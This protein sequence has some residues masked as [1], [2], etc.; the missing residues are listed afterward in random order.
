MDGGFLPSLSPS[1][2]QNVVQLIT[3][4]YAQPSGAALGDANGQLYDVQKSPLAW[5]LVVPLLT[6]GAPGGGDG[7]AVHFFGAHT[8]VVKAARD[9]DSLPAEHRNAFRDLMLALT[10][11]SVRRGRPMLVLRKL[12]VCLTSLAIRLAPRD[13]AGQAWADWVLVCFTTISGA[14]SS[15]STR[16]KLLVHEFLTIAAEE[17]PTADVV[18]PSRKAQLMQTLIDSSSIIT[19]MIRTELQEPSSDNRPLAAAVR[20]L[21]AWLSQLRADDLTSLI[22]LLLARLGDGKDA[23]TFT[24]IASAL[25]EILSRAPAYQNGAGSRTLTE[26][27]LLWLDGS[28]SRLVDRIVRA[29]NSTAGGDDEDLDDEVPTRALVDLLAALGEH[30]VE[31]IARWV[32]SA[33]VVGGGVME[34]PVRTRGELVQNFLSTVLALTVLPYDGE[35]RM[36]PDATGNSLSVAGSST[37]GNPF[38]ATASIT[39]AVSPTASIPAATLFDDAGGVRGEALLAFWYQLQEEVWSVDWDED[40]GDGEGDARGLEEAAW[41]DAHRAVP[42]F[43][44]TSPTSSNVDQEQTRALSAVRAVYGRLVRALR[45]KVVFPPRAETGEWMKDQVDRFKTYRRDVG[46]TL[47]NAYYVLRDEMLAYYVNDVLERLSRP[48]VEWEQVEATLHCLSSIDEALPSAEDAAESSDEGASTAHRTPALLSRVLGPEV[49]ARLPSAGTPRVR[50]T[51]LG[52][53]DTYAAYLGHPAMPPA[54]LPGALDYATDALREPRLSL[55]AANAL[56]SVCD[57]NRSILASRVGISAFGGVAEMCVGEGGVPDAEK[58]KVLQSV[59]SVIQA[60]DPVEGIAPVEALVSPLVSRAMSAREPDDV[61]LRLDILVG[62]ARGLQRPSQPLEDAWTE[63]EGG[64][65]AQEAARMA[66]AREDPRAASLRDGLGALMRHCTEAWGQDVGVCTSLSDLIKALSAAAPLD[67]GVLTVPPAPLMELVCGALQRSVNGTW[68]ALLAK[69]TASLTAATRDPDSPFKR[70]PGEEARAVVSRV[71]PAVIGT[72]LPWF[73][74][75]DGMRNN[76][77]VAQE[78]FG[79]MERFA[80][81][82]TPE[83]YAMPEGALDGLMR[84]AIIALGLQERYSMVAACKFIRAIF[85][86]TCTVDVLSQT[87]ARQFLVQAY[88]TLV[89]RAAVEGIAGGTPPSTHVNLIDLLQLLSL[90]CS[91]DM[92]RW[93]GEVLFAADFM[94][95][96]RAGPEAKEKFAKALISSRSLKKTRDACQSFSLISRGLDGTSFGYATVVA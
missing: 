87:P 95:T 48:V 65:L 66:Q 86:R 13:S 33:R 57:A 4:A 37:D 15:D 53:L 18:D 76:P 67:M 80:E 43:A 10:A 61:I 58:G 19:G 82:Y 22:P 9:W 38:S 24:S 7:T 88:F 92:K 39:P 25:A 46:D 41:R 52:L 28:G 8:A 89:L 71:L 63:G 56:R 12:F 49:L 84:C 30:S 77:D 1:D 44:P 90:R 85:H 23:D 17:I 62:V 3:A 6:Y 69:L 47:I 78:F 79:L 29:S 45:A 14:A 73:G 74:G 21:Q 31:Y 75:V 26:P 68:L 27:L 93:A 59:A 83:L 81:E 51:A 60:V 11:D 70:D 40:G 54:T 91:E 72:V 42:S 55:V 5:G 94:P 2:I 34:A 50:R 32:A 36:S 35:G 20:T 96:S 64:R 16:A